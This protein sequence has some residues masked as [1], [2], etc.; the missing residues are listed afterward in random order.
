MSKN[1]RAMALLRKNNLN[2]ARMTNMR[3]NY[4]TRWIA[5]IMALTMCGAVKAED[6]PEVAKKDTKWVLDRQAQQPEPKVVITNV[7]AWPN[8]TRLPNGDIV[9]FIYNQPS[10]GQMPGDVD[11]WASTDEGET[12]TKRSVA[13]PRGTPEQNRMNVAAGLTAEGNLIL[14]TSGWSQPGNPNAEGQANL[15]RKLPVWVCISKDGGKTWNI[16]KNSFPKAPD[17]R[18]LVP[19]GDIMPGVDGKLRVAAYCG[20]LEKDAPGMKSDDPLVRRAAGGQ[21]WI[22]CGDGITW[23]LFVPISRRPRNNET[24]LLHLGNGKWL[25]A[26]R[27]GRA[28]A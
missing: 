7:C 12:W 20:P 18:D 15:G 9:A 6:K 16:N 14:I 26:A 10:H 22:V 4:P 5:A 19:F 11:C 27:K 21:N 2:E 13:A 23:T 28:M 3:R 8:L 17:G 24:A 1:K 25:A